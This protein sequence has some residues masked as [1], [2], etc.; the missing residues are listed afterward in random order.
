MG[1]I[2]KFY[3]FIIFLAVVTGLL[4]GKVDLIQ[5]HADSILIPL[6]VIMLYLTF[7][8]I[9]FREIR[10]SFLNLK[11]SITALL[12][13][14]VWVPFLAWVLVGLFL[15]HPA[16]AIGFIM[17]MVTPCT[18]WYLIFTGVARGNLALSTAILPLNLILQILLL[19]IFLLLFT[20]TRGGIEG[21]YFIEGVVIVLLLPL[22]LAGLTQLLLK[23][24]EQL[25]SKILSKLSVLPIVFLAFAIMAMFASHGQLLVE[26]I[27][28]LWSLILPVLL[29]FVLNFFFG[30]LVGRS[31]KFSYA[32]RA[33]L[34]LTTLARNSPIALALAMTAFPDQPLI[35]LTLIIGPLIEL[36]VLA[37]VTQVLVWQR[38]REERN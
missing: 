11:F 30:Q 33:S 3:T 34:S 32:D 24:K 9:R 20:G 17:L 21:A 8:H 23:N 2:E 38:K 4:L 6:L 12:I 37:V 18:D 10:S 14:F 31:L 1:M 5:A 26:N 16:L 7:L 25:Q 15:D 22:L 27:E 36:P 13:N 28:L 19:P 29:F 35:A